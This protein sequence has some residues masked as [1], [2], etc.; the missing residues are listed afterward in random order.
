MNYRHG[1][2]LKQVV[3]QSQST[4]NLPELI[5]MTEWEV[6]G[7]PPRLIFAVAED[8][9]SSYAA[10]AVANGWLIVQI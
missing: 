5:V 6:N 2:S 10:V 8:H 4:R 7:P 1:S 3:R 9:H